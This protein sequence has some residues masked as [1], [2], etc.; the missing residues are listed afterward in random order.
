MI[1]ISVME[2]STPEISTVE[3]STSPVEISEPTN[4]FMTFENVAKMFRWRNL[5]NEPK[6][7]FLNQIFLMVEISNPGISIVEI[8][9]D[10]V[11]NR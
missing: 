1:E 8:L 6:K 2:I 9:I 10:P 11:E 3:I 5:E 7:H 4:R